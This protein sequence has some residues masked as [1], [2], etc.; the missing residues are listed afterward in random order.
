MQV[1]WNKCQATRRANIFFI[2]TVKLNNSSSVFFGVLIVPDHLEINTYFK[3][4]LGNKYYSLTESK[5]IIIN[6]IYI[7]LL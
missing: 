1:I 6:F 4:R 5:N 3:N 2:S 7:D